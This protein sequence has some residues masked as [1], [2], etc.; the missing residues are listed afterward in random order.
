MAGAVGVATAAS[1]RAVWGGAPPGWAVPDALTWL[2][3]VAA[4][5]G[6]PRAGA[7][8]P[9]RVLPLGLGVGGPW[10]FAAGVALAGIGATTTRWA[11]AAFVCLL[12]Q[13]ALHGPL[14]Q[15]AW[16]IA[17]GAGA[18]FDAASVGLRVAESALIVAAWCCVGV[19]D[20]WGGGP[21]TR[22]VRRAAR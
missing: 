8:S 18:S 13:G 14:A 12:L 11:R 6:S 5:W 2:V 3:L 9:W 20:P 7:S 10:A 21:A 4:L 1:A 19:G 22:I 17:V 15:R 16:T